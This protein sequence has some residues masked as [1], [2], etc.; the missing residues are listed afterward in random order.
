M[1]H[2]ILWTPSSDRIETATI[3]RYQEWLAATHGVRTGSY[4]E[5]WRW[6][7]DELE[8]FWGSIVEFF[9]VRFE[10]AGERVLDSMTMPGANW[11][12]GSRVSY[13][14][15][16]FAGRDPAAL[17]IH[18]C[19][20]LREL[21]AWSWSDLRQQ[22][23]AIAAGLRD[24]GVGAGDRVAAYLPNIPRRSPPSSRVRRS[25][26]SGHRPRPNSARA[27]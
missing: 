10:V 15:H 18:H 17:A 6:S 1:E 7:V 22:T 27:A 13:A 16:I 19:S 2:E 21:S 8:S 14:E 12:P 3:S 25:V 4:E 26:R 11:F 9:G 5:L 20:E 23:A 24:L